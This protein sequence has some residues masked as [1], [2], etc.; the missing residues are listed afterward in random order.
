MVRRQPGLLSVNVSENILKVTEFFKNEMGLGNGQ[1]SKVYCSHPQASLFV[2][3]Q[4]G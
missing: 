2:L 1:I 3:R 4:R